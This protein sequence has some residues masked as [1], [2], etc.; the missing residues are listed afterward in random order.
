M[1][2]VF[3]LCLSRGYV[4][5]LVQGQ[6]ETLVVMQKMMHSLKDEVTLRLNVS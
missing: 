4:F 3:E 2:N 6:G 5:R 1:V